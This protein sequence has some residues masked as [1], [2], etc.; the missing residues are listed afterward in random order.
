[1]QAELAVVVQVRRSCRRER[2]HSKLEVAVVNLVWLTL[3][4]RSL[5]KD[6]GSSRLSFAIEQIYIHSQH[7]CRLTFLY[8]VIQ[9]YQNVSFGTTVQSPHWR[10]NVKIAT[11]P[12]LRD[13]LT[14][15]AGI[16]CVS[17]AKPVSA[18]LR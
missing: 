13:Q 15:A 7:A 5:R 17:A 2:I 6:I 14:R 10:E 4:L 3:P 11:L 18:E 16:D 12:L 1:M 9:K 8:C